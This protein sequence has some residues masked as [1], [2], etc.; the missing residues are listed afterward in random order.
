MIHLIYR[1]APTEKARRNQVDFWKWVVERQEW[2][3]DGLDTVLETKWYVVTIGADVHALEHYAS[4]ADEAGWGA[5]R[6]ELSRRSRDKAWEA[7]RVSQDDWWHMLDAR[8]LSDAP[9]P[10]LPRGRDTDQEQP[11]A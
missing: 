10:P 3:Y 9:V 7:R 8:I 1:F 6:R 5:Y 2:F 4:F 11:E